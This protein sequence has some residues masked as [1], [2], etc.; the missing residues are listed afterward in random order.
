[1]S[2]TRDRLLEAA[3]TVIR[4]EGPA[5]ATSR[6][7]TEAAGVNLAA[8]TYHFG[9]KDSLLG[10]AVVEQLRRWTEPLTEALASDAGD[11][12]YYDE[13][14]ATAVA[15]ML[16]RFS[17]GPDEVQAVITLLLTNADLPGVRDAL[18]TWLAELRALATDVMVR[19]QAAGVIPAT[20][21]PSAMAA[22]FTAL[23]LGV[24]TQASLDA[25]APAAPSVVAEFLSLLIR[26]AAQ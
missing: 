22:V 5:A 7:I 1:M 3:W 6:R 4:D 9:S 24:G 19:Q 18:V 8:I 14:V 20:V 25:N 17:T 21:N 11:I 13:R 26:P 12:G 23:A 2:A 16:S 15:A 10:E